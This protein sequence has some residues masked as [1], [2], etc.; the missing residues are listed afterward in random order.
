MDIRAMTL[1]FRDQGFD[2]DMLRHVFLKSGL[3]YF[4]KWSKYGDIM[5]S[6]SKL[7]D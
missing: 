3:R 2:N 5:A 4:Y 6:C 1:K 7:F